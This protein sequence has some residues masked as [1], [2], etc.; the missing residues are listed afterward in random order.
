MS[1]LSVVPPVEGPA[2]SIRVQHLDGAVDAYPLTPMQEAMLLRSQREPDAGF[3]VQQFVCTLHEPLRVPEL[4]SAWERL[5]SRH[6]V[7]RTSF[8]L[9]ASPVSF[10]RVHAAAA[11]PWEERD[12]RG[13]A[14]DAREAAMR[15]LLHEDR[16]IPFRPEEAPLARWTLLRIGEEEY[17]LVWTSHHA[18]FDGHARRHLLREVF[19]EYEGRPGTPSRTSFGEYVRWLLDAEPP[20]SRAFWQGELRGF[21]APNELVLESGDGTTAGRERHEFGI[22]EALTAALRDLAHAQ[23]V[24]LGTVVHAAWALLLSRYTGDEDVVFG[25]TRACRRGGFEGAGEVVGLLSNTV[26]LRAHVG[27]GETV[28]GLLQALRASWVRMRPH[29]RTHLS[30]IQEW[31]GLPGGTPL[32]QTVLA[33]E[34]ETTGDALRRLGDGWRRRTFDLRQCTSYPLAV[35]AHGG[36]SAHFVV[37]YDPARYDG[38]AVRRLGDHLAAVLGAFAEDPA[39]PLARVGLLS[40]AERRHLTEDVNPRAAVPPVSGTLHARFAAQAGRTPGAAAVVHDGETLTYGELESRANRLAHALRA[41][42]VGPE[43]RVGVCMER[44]QELVVALLGV[45]KAGGAYVPLDP[46]YPPERLAYTAAD[47]DLRVIFAGAGLRDRLRE[48]S[49]EVLTWEEIPACD[50]TSAPGVPVS[51]GNLAYVIYTSG[52]TGRPKGVGVTH[53]NVLRLF[54]C[55]APRFGFGPA[56]VWTLFHSYGFDF[57]VWEIWGALLYGGRLVV[58]PWAVSRDPSAFRELLRRERVTVLNQTPSAFRALAEADAASPSPLE[59]LRAVVFGGEALAYGSLGGWL[60]RYGARRPR[61]VNM[62]GITETTVHVTWHTVTRAAPDGVTAGSCV[63][64]PI[65]D[66]RAYVLDPA[67][68]LTPVGVPGEIHVGGPGL[69]RGYLGRPALTAERFV[70]D[71]FSG[72][73]G[74]RLYRSGDLARWTGDGT[75]EYRGR[76]DQ[77]VKV[78]GFRIE[79]GEI[80][81]ALLGRPG[82]TSAAVVARGE[83]GDAALVAYVVGEGEAASPHAL[84]DALRERLPDYMVPAVFVPV[85]RIPLTANGKLDRRALPDPDVAAPGERHVAPR[86]PA[87]EVLA[88]I[89][90]EVLG[91]ARVG[92]EDGFLALGGHS[93]LATRVVS[94]ARVAL[95]VEISLRSLL[96]G[97]TVAGLAR[98]VEEARGEAPPPLPPVRR[99]ARDRSLPLSFGQ[100]RLWFIHRMDPGSAAYHVPLFHRLQGPLD[101][102]ALRL[103]FETVAARHEALRTLFRE[104]DGEP[105]QVVLPPSRFPLPL[106]DLSGRP[107]GE[108]E[109]LRLAEKEAR[110]PFRL[111][112]GPLLRAILV[113]VEPEIH[114]LLATVH[115]IAADGWST[116]VLAREVAACYAAALAG[117]APALLPLP[118]Q[119]ADYAVWERETAT[120]ER[121]A[122]ALAHWREHLGDAEP[123][124]LAADRLRAAGVRARG[125]TVRTALPPGLSRGARAFAR[126]A[127]ATPFVVLLSAFQALLSRWTGA[128]EVVVGTPV[129]RR[130][131]A[132]T[133]GLIGFFVNTVALR[134]R[135]AGHEGFRP[136]VARLREV[137]LAAQAHRWAPYEQVAAELQRVRGNGAPLFRVMLAYEAGAEPPLRLPGVA[138]ARLPVERAAPKFDL[139]LSLED[140][141]EEIAAAWEFDASLFERGTVERLAAGLV[142]LLAGALAAPDAPVGALP[143]LSDAERAALLALGA[144]AEVAAPRGTVHERIAAQAARTPGAIAVEAAGMR[145]TYAELDARAERL[146]AR[147]RAAGVGPEVRVGVC[148]ERSAA[149][150][151]SFLAVLKAGGVYVPLDPAHPAERLAGMAGDAGLRVL[152][153]AEETRERLPRGGIAVLSP[154]DAGGGEGFRAPRVP[155]APANLAYVLYTSGSTGPPKG[156][157]IPHGALASHMAWMDG[158]LPLAPSDRVLQRTPATFDASLWELCAPLM[159]GAT[160][161]VGGVEAHR[162]GA[163][164]LRAVREDRITVLQLVP[165]LLAAVLEEAGPAA[166][167]S[168]RRLCCGGEAL[169]TA[170]AGRARAAFGAEVVNLY[171]PTEV[172][173]DAASAV[174]ATGN[175]SATVPIGRPV[176]RARA[177]VVDAA[178]SLVPPGVPGELLL[179]GAQLAR[180]YLGRPGLTAER[181]VPDPFGTEAG[182]RLYR[183][184]DRTRWRPDGALEFL[185]RLD[186][187]VKLRGLRVEP[188]EIEAVLRRHPL[189]R[190]CAVVLREDAHGE[191]RLAAYVV[192]GAEA[193]ALRAHQRRALPEPL[194]PGAIV[195]LDRLPLTPNGKLDRRALPPPHPVPSADAYTPP[196][197]PEEE[198]LAGIWADLLRLERVGVEETFLALGGHSLLATRVVSRVRDALGVELPLRALLEDGTVAA[199]AR[200]VEEA[201]GAGRAPLPPVVPVPRDSLLPLSFAQERLWFLHRLSPESPVYNLPVARR[202]TGT[203]D[204]ATLERAL[205]EV[206]RRHEALRTVI[207]EVDGAPVQSVLPFGGFVL[208]V[209]DLGGAGGETREAPLRRRL[210]EEAARPFDLSADPP[211]RATLLRLGEREHVLVLCLHHVAADAW[212]VDLL[213]RELSCLYAPD[214]AR[215]PP[216]LSAPPVQYADYAAWQRTALS[217]AALESDLAYW[218]GSLAGAPELLELPA[219]HP[220]PATQ[221]FRGAAVRVALPAGTLDRLRAVGRSEGTTLHTVLLAA[222]K[223]LLSRYAGEEDVS[224]GTPVAGRTRRETEGVIGFFVNT[225]VLRTDLGGNPSFRELLRRVRETALGAYA[226]QELPFERLVS[227]LRPERSLAHTPLFQVSFTLAEAG[228]PG[229]ILPGVDT[230]EIEVPAETAKFDLSLGLEAEHAGLRGTLTYA[231]D[232]FEPATAKRMAER[233]ERLIEQAAADPGARLSTLRLMGEA[234]R[235]R[236]VEGW[237][238]APRRPVGSLHARFAAAAAAAPE[239]VAAVCG[240]E[241]LTYGE[242]RHRAGRLAA[243]LRG[244]GVG[245]EVRVALCLERSLDTLV[246]ILGVLEAGGAYVPV[247]P[248]YPPER[249]SYLLEDAGVALV[250]AQDGTRDVLAPVTAAPVLLLDA[251]PDVPARDVP[252]AEVDPENAAYVIYTSGSTG[253]P[254][255]VVVTHASVLRLFD[256]TEPWFGFGPDDVWTLFHSYAFDFSVWEIWGALLHGGRLVVV[257]FGTSRDPAAFRALLAREGVTVLNQTPSAF[258]QLV[259]ADEGTDD[260]LS[261]RWVV[262]GGEALEPRSLRPWFERHGDRRPRLVNMYGITE[263]TVHVT[264]RPLSAAD[265]EAG[266][267]AIGERIPDLGLYLLDAEVEPVPVGITGEIFVGGAGVARGYLGRPAL[268]AERFLPDPISG[269]PGAR[270]YRSGDRARARGPRDADYL[271]RCDQQVKVRGFRIEPGEVEAA[272]LAYPGVR[273]AAVVARADEPGTSRLVAYVVAAEGAP[274]PAALRAHLAASLPDYMVPSAFVPLDALPLTPHGKLDHR[275]LPLPER[276][277]GRDETGYVPPRGPVEEAL[278]AAWA[279]ALGVER[280]GAEDNY[281]ALGGDSMRAIQLLARAR[282]RGVPFSLPDIFRHQTVAALA[283]RVR[284]ADTAPGE[285]G[286]APFALLAPGDRARVDEGV[287]DAYPATQLQLGMLFHTERSGDEAVYH[288]VQTIAVHAPFEE[289]R[290]RAALHALV[291]RHPALRTSF[292]LAAFSEPLQLVHR[293]VEAP[294][295]VTSLAHLETEAQEAAVDTWVRTE[296]ARPF[297]PGRPPLIRFH[298]HVLGPGE[299]RFGFAE[300]HA[301]LDGWSVATLLGELFGDGG[302]A[303]DTP[304]PAAS[305]LPAFVALEREALASTEARS[306]WA[307]KLEDAVPVLP[308]ALGGAVGAGNRHR[309]GPVPAEAAAALAETARRHGLPL[310]S[311]LLAAHLRVLAAAA[312]EDDV[313]TGIVVNG[314]PEG[315]DGERAL[316]LFLNTVPLRVRLAAGSWLALARAAFEEERS[317][318]PFRRF[319]IAELKRMHGGAPF[320]ALFNFVHFHGMEAAGAGAGRLGARRGAGGTSFSFGASFEAVPGG[321]RLALEY[322]AG[323][324]AEEEAE[325]LF[326]RYLAALEA[327][328]N[329]P[330]GRYDRHDLLSSAERERLAAWSV[331][332]PAAAAEPVHLAV[333]ARAARDPGA[334]AV[335]GAGGALTYAELEAAANRLARHLRER[336]ARRGTRVAVT[337]ERSPELPVAL[338]A[339]LRAGAAYVP[340]D[341]EHPAERRAWV[342]ADAGATLLVTRGPAAGTGAWQGEVVDL[343][344]ARERIAAL[345][346]EPPGVEAHPEDLAYVLYTSGSTGRPKGVAVP[347][348]ALA[349]HMG[350]MQRAFPLSPDDRVLQK[351]PVGFDASV[352]EFWAPLMAG[353]TLVMAPPEAHR[354]A[355]EMLEALQRERITVLQLVP[356]LLRAVL[357]HPWPAGSGPL[358]RLFCG[359]EALPAE[360]AARAR[361]R[362]GAEVVNLYGPTEACIDATSHPF[363]GESSPTVPIGRPVDGVDAHVLDRAGNLVAPGVAGELYLGGAQLAR[364]YLGRAALTAERFVPD[365]RSGRP[366]TRLYRTGDRVRRLADGVMEFLERVDDQVK[367]GGHRM[368]PAEVECALRAHPAVAD[369]AV[370]S[371][372][373]GSGTARLVAYVTRAPDAAP[374]PAAL[375]AHLRG[376]LP[377]AMIPSVYVVLDALPLT[378]SGKLDRRALPAPGHTLQDRP[379]VSP[380]DALEA[381]IAS[382]WEDVLGAGPAGV[383]DDFFEAGGHSLGALRLLASVERVTGRRAPMAAFLREPTV[384]RLARTIRAG[385]ENAPQGSLVPLR[386]AGAGRPVFFVHAAGGHAVSYAALARHLGTGQPSYALQ[387]RGLEGEGVPRASVEEM[388]RAYLAELRSVQ[389]EGPYLLGGWSMGGLVAF[390]LARR[391]EAEGEG[392][393]L[394]ALLD[395]RAPGDAALRV[396]PDDPRLLESFLLHLG[397]PSERVPAPNGCAG[398]EERLLR[399]WKAAREAEVVPADVDPARFGWMWAV[400]RA[401]VAAAARYRPGPCASDLLVVV[402][403]E[404]GPSPFSGPEAWQRLTTGTVRSAP[405]PG[406]HFTLLQ[407]PHVRAVAERIRASLSPGGGS[408]AQKGRSDGG[409]APGDR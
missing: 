137:T 44:S 116:G 405:V 89:W 224:V 239:A 177:Y 222:W 267:S 252:P 41:R 167:G 307:G 325:A 295:T 357:E 251:L 394:L 355:G 132:E 375:R 282:A 63:G 8:H 254:K 40:P 165:S 193:G 380:R 382:L 103:A 363:A 57:S 83:G 270:M 62:Y 98:R 400:F 234:E 296:R 170:L 221:S 343:D 85:D 138:A 25:A 134:G 354:D 199:L 350:W 38:A 200:R 384:E 195:G 348:G 243:H 226:H 135:V 240:A 152:L 156:V 206:V 250:V 370:L 255:G 150:V 104:E 387:A 344:A 111:D 268:T 115:H 287:E 409:S 117:E 303:R 4:R 121:L 320:A 51:A 28:A 372:D 30:R 48:T 114:L 3:Y 304:A 262:F 37:S 406:T 309:S 283:S 95:G 399:A 272:I 263:T 204:V 265:V 153:A 378:S 312:G 356:S 401:N 162:D 123:L 329:D 368:E 246:A 374:E 192:G 298:V 179:G 52:S 168:L 256:A 84:R 203:L 217:G 397:T 131:R 326:A 158:A 398:A 118:V 273:E 314:R 347:H 334:T 39:Q 108:A 317:A 305:V 259:H 81:S 61:L 376:R 109:A 233:L 12:W 351:T 106:I 319:P 15:D 130:E 149:L 339:V 248:A 365:P 68:R 11:L 22:S 172:T 127:G 190:E 24:T 381:R 119:Y 66:L 78:R 231:T 289:G 404:A 274:H 238:P 77:Q 175:P 336:G 176:D 112:T 388:A 9:D 154:D 349:N 284:P 288:N 23:G 185:G 403:E 361:A 142:R 173:I 105:R 93:L 88:G 257:P 359:G 390:E 294:L 186:A 1:N 310:K 133:E 100:E 260:D 353:A 183:T 92:V 189:V 332:A 211:L 291:R 352:W 46:S 96:E 90:A 20:G 159:A 299:F 235:T 74:A 393:A 227:A 73:S 377:A 277:A 323:R 318:L 362:F 316:G 212:S 29:E 358:R 281:F 276:S 113:R 76:I 244:R 236:V 7:L 237:R 245:P 258:R 122:A 292:D 43:A 160:L 54:D 385:G 210:A 80:E 26:P 53:G 110:R 266:R 205:G 302:G 59:E 2:G 315:P 21:D 140:A 213:F 163:E 306:F 216:A 161:V 145:F 202:F 396:E 75:L 17:R 191:A 184:G 247:D 290:V 136:L 275:A 16:S 327:I 215:R 102:E 207:R 5:V 82:V 49:A 280:V 328:A 143:L 71:P 308:A 335:A 67:G 242:L 91:V 120:G 395:T 223:L 99:V 129:A 228:P 27:R 407:E 128:E 180:G 166:G 392:V 249:I 13:L 346:P 264:Y 369:C 87:E 279:E 139:V 261:L 188:G 64:K 253:R 391:L 300:H 198:V 301:I 148:L 69:A 278:A 94:R 10:Q 50:A 164:I 151:T 124:P 345:S 47:A 182:A 146:A 155:I 218:T 157:G 141:G 107:D 367:V 31:S 364:G 42:G 229:P 286:P 18:L 187:Q 220:R 45:L 333:S 360:L 60:D 56:D 194:V 14:P 125:E 389:P 32:F 214:P 321:L 269:V 337:L 209:E 408:R 232:L 366:G 322:D 97:S 373:D 181:F 338:L 313:T 169:P 285:E 36:A 341:P 324:Y 342:L 219:D 19:D 331:G 208:P 79:L 402:A 383:R 311:L 379:Y 293:E 197:T 225:L 201:R 340:V 174:H 55:T 65:P 171:G 34:R 230:A 126:E 386:G 371:L 35:V 33:F 330:E 86:T 72:E 196:R 297:D 144:G 6:P 70:P 58:V 101:A 147:L 178:T 271:G 241:R